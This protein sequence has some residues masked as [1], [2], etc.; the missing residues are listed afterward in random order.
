VRS[1]G[2]DKA[3]IH[4]SIVQVRTVRVGTLATPSLDS[5]QISDGEENANTFLI[6]R[7]PPLLVS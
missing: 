1:S 5:S 6:S 7:E 3:I 2:G 4:K